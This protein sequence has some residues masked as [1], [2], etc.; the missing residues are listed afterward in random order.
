M[1]LDVQIKSLIV[2]FIF[3]IIT[4]YLVKINYKYL[5]CRNV[6]LKIIVSTFFIIDLILI[7]FI[8]L[9]NI[10]NGIY[11]FYFLI[12]ILLGYILGYKLVNK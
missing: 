11:H 7:Y 1:S 6:V 9:R 2:S 3:G 12:M 8:L 4:S 5:F 10:N